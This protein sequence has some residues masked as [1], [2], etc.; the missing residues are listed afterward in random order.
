V[1]AAILCQSPPEDTAKLF[2]SI[3]DFDGDGFLGPIDIT[4][5]TKSLMSALNYYDEVPP[6][7]DSEVDEKV[8][9]LMTKWDH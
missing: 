5:F 1:G 3:Y 8:Q 7:T 2:F 6:P 4:T 9:Q